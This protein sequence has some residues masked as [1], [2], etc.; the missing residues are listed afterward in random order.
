M[1]N[2]G[3][4]QRDIEKPMPT[5][6]GNFT[7]TV[8]FARIVDVYDASM[9]DSTGNSKDYGH[10][11]VVFLDSLSTPPILIPY[12]TPWYSW[13]RGSG[14][15]YMPE[16]NDIVACLEQLNGYPVVIGFLP[17]KWDQSLNK[18]VLREHREFGQTRPLYKGEVYI[19]GSAGGSLLLD[20]NGTVTLDGTDYSVSEKVVSNVDGYNSEYSFDRTLP[21]EDSGI[22]KTIVGNSYLVDGTVK[23]VGNFPQIF[24]SGAATTSTAMLLLPFTD[25]I[26]FTLPSDV[27]ITQVLS[28]QVVTRASSKGSSQKVNKKTLKDSQYHLSCENIYQ[29]GSLES[30]SKDFKPATT[31]KNSYG[32]TLTVNLSGLS[33]QAIQLNY[34]SRKFV[35]GVRVNSVGDVFIDGRNVIIRSENERSGLTLK[36][37]GEASIYG[38]NRTT[39]GIPGYGFIDCMQNG[40]QYSTGI[41][42]EGFLIDDGMVK[43]TLKEIMSSSEGNVAYYY[44]SDSLPL[45]KVQSE[46][47]N[48]NFS[49]V[50]R[51]EYM[52]L[53]SNTKANIRK[54]W[55]SISDKLFNEKKLASM[56]NSSVLSYGELKRLG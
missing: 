47:S 2:I 42:G 18:A 13:T 20:K 53:S 40:I 31:E 48:W 8:R 10:L 54:I 28:V 17:Y 37:D 46:G 11:S 39:L 45:I 7:H 30:S 32:Y 38:T 5:E 16:Q 41:L 23:N 12:T 3:D 1:R 4:L 43:A 25:E 27:E 49:G 50:T 36:R 22:S 9:L 14:I 15:M 21:I 33:G 34:L 29:R 44:I 51:D 56:L 55:F 6:L 35:G 24:E 26:R 19:K 52:S